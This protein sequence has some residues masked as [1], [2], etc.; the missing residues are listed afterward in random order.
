MSDLYDR[1]PEVISD[2]ML[3]AASAMVDDYQTSD[4]HHPNHV[5][6]SRT[7]FEAMLS[8]SPKEGK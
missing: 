2:E 6:V 8:A 7:A 3:A 4:R 1:R 5:L